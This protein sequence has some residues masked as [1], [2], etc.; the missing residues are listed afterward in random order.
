MISVSFCIQF[1]GPVKP[2]VPSW[3]LYTIAAEWEDIDTELIFSVLTLCS[4]INR[5]KAKTRNK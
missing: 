2:L 3:L 1:F 4:K 5:F